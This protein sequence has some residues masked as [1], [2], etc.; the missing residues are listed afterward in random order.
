MI[1]VLSL[2]VFL[3]CLDFVYLRS[4]DSSSSLHP[5]ST[6][7]PLAIEFALEVRCDPQFSGVPETI[8]LTGE[9]FS[10]LG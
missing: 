8:H 7:D 2:W 9:M 1:I 6:S 3:F 10:E 5:T 4:S